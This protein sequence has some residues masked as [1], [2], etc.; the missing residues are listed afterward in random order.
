MYFEEPKGG[1]LDIREGY[2]ASLNDYAPV[3]ETKVTE[4]VFAVYT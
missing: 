3:A 2:S 1:P 4:L